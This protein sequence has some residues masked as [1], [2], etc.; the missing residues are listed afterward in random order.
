[1]KDCSENTSAPPI[2]PSGPSLH[3]FPHSDSALLAYGL[4]DQE[5]SRL[6]DMVLLRTKPSPPPPVSFIPHPGHMIRI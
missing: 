2:C 4:E 5:S 3:I 1:M 6:F